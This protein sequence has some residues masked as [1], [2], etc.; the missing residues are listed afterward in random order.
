M[1]ILIA[2]ALYPPEISDI[3]VHCKE[4]AV[5]LADEN[6]INVLAYS[7]LPEKTKEVTVFKVNKMRPLPIRLVFFTMQLFTIARKADVVFVENGVSVELPAVLLAIFTNKPFVV[8]IGDKSAWSTSRKNVL[9]RWTQNILIRRSLGVV[10]SMPLKKPEI[11]PFNKTK[12]SDIVAY[13][14][15]WISH[16]KDI[17]NL[18]KI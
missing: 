15:S 2:T 13:N 14:N 5:R 9:L 7:T 8:H 16:M 17:K 11:L 1:N 12:E 3:A 6:E 18:L 10:E 4:L